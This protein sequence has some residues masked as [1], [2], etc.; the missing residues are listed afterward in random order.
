MKPA[1]SILI[2][3][4]TP[5]NL[6]VLRDILTRAGYRVRPVLQGALALKSAAADPPDLIL[7]DIMMP[8]M[9]GYETCRGLKADE[10][11]ADIPVLFISALD[12]TENK[13][14]GFE[15]GGL[16]YIT[17]PFRAEEVLA[18]VR[19]HVALREAQ[20]QLK[21]QNEELRRAAALREDVDRMLRHDLRGSLANVIGY[22]ELLAEE[23]DPDGTPAE[24]ARVIVGAGY[25]MLSMIHSSFDLMKMERGVYEGKPEPFDI[26]EVARQVLDELGLD[27]DRKHLEHRICLAEPGTRDLIVRGERL[28][29]HSLFHN[30]VKNAIEASPVGGILEFRLSEKEGAAKIQLRNAGAVPEVIRDRFFDKFVTYGKLDGT[31]LGTYSAKLMAETQGGT[32]RLDASE[33]GYTSVVVTLPLAPEAEA[34]QFR[35]SWTEEAGANARRAVAVDL[36]PARILIADDD[37]ANRAYL[38][39]L[40]SNSPLELVF[41]ENG[42]EALAAMQQQQPAVALMDLEMPGFGG[43]EVA[44]R[45]QEWFAREGASRS[46]PV[47]IAFS[48]HQGETVRE[49]CLA[50]GFERVLGKPVAKKR[51]LKELEQ[52][53]MPCASA[54][55]VHIDREIKDLMPDFLELQHGLI[56]QLETIIAGGDGAKT[57][58][59]AHRLQGSFAM[60]G[61]QSASR[62]AIDIEDAGKAEN[63]T[64]ARSLASDLRAH[65]TSLEFH[66]T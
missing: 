13:V 65:L 32:I 5:E 47:M 31:G 57:R 63:F 39:R 60:Y 8:V 26:A 27:S 3:D 25:S 50:A 40:L 43:I 29:C 15:E 41:A 38:R 2:V 4:D 10:R 53:L 14:R 1:A 49:H 21:A 30:L 66:Y 18:R 9:D 56:G 7:L 24:H 11:T 22:S 36:P 46:R 6:T 58:S 55:R 28:L 19:T 51:L 35:A 20:L 54:V 34:A 44:Q 48:G 23:V 17:K 33:Q 12:A 61:L 59:L 45:F 42:K 62:I 52:A 16:D 64:R 37:A